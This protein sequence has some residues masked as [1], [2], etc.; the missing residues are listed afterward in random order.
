MATMMNEA[1][2]MTKPRMELV[3]LEPAS[4][5]ALGSEPD[6]MYFKPARTRFKNKRR[7]PTTVINL[8]RL[9]TK[10]IRPVASSEY[11]E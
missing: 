11:P 9:L 2:M 10:T 5:M 8:I 4:E 1:A 6:I 3:I 7:P